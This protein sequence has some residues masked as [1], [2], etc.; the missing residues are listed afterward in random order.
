MVGKLASCLIKTRMLKFSR[1]QIQNK[2]ET[3]IDNTFEKLESL[4]IT[5]KIKENWRPKQNQGNPMRIVIIGNLH[6]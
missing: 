3:M 2:S 1:E 5:L 6:S 4:Y